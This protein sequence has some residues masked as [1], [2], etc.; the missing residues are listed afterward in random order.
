MTVKELIELLSTFPPDQRVMFGSSWEA[1][2]IYSETF[3]R[4]GEET[5]HFV[6]II[7]GEVY[8]K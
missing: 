7:P 2:S 3:P 6:R 4:R 8:A 1:Q 5:E